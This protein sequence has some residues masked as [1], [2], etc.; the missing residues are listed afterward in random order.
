MDRLQ[1]MQVFRA[2]IEAGSFAGGARRLGVSN[3]MVSKQV[4]RLA[5]TLGVP[6]RQI[7]VR[8]VVGRTRDPA[9]GI[10]QVAEGAVKKSGLAVL[11]HRGTPLRPAVLRIGG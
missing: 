7:G 3:A 1:A 9:P 2:V 6:F 10:A 8:V 4:S 11:G 5:E